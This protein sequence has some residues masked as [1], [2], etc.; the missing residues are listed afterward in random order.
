MIKLILADDHGI[1]VEGLK[2]I[3]TD[4]PGIKVTGSAAN[5]KEVLD[6]LEK[7]PADIVLMD[8]TMPEM[9]GVTTTEII[10]Q[11]FPDV[12][13]LV[14]SMHNDQE[15]IKDIVSLG[16]SGYILK[17]TGKQ[18]MLK[19]IKTVA[20]GSLYF[21]EEVTQTI[22]TSFTQE[23]DQPAATPVQLTPREIDILRL[24][25]KEYTT[26]EIAQELCIAVNT[27]ESH[28]KNLHSKLNVKNAAGLVKYA[29][30]N[31]LVNIN[32]SDQSGKIKE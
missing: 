10:K 15:T 26:A 22:L 23:K 5:G 25:V 28:R 2:A 4:E 30:K 12:K 8:I 27:V 31:G 20:D 21:S 24:I 17:N 7:N 16:A 29:I 11:R 6:L 3:L 14:L 1:V 13:I 19:A 9:D 32:E 18:E